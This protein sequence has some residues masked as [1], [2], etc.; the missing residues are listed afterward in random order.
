R[1]AA[2]VRLQQLKEQRERVSFSAAREAH[3]LQNKLLGQLQSYS[4]EYQQ[5]NIAGADRAVSIASL[6][7]GSHFMANLSASIARQQQQEALAAGRMQEAR[8]AWEQEMAKLDSLTS[9]LE[10]SRAEEIRELAHSADLEAVD[11]WQA[12]A[13]GAARRV[14]SQRRS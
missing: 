3:A 13:L 1:L 12:V 10:R 5:L 6:R 11:I 14:A 4:D 9:L 7:N 8:R 2:V